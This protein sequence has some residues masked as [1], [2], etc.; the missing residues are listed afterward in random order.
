M[1]KARAV[2]RT[3]SRFENHHFFDPVATLSFSRLSPQR[4]AGAAE[5]LEKRQF[6]GQARQ[7]VEI[8]GMR[9]IAR[10]LAIYG[11]LIFPSKCCT[12]S[13]RVINMPT[14]GF[15]RIRNAAMRRDFTRA[16]VLPMFSSAEIHLGLRRGSRTPRNGNGL[17]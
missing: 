1:I 17:R 14:R 3:R 15:I 9:A 4:T 6:P 2:S 5:K 8:S 12:R 10:I 11:K 7:A 13:A 16:I